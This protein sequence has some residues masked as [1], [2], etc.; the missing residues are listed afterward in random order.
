MR[1]VV[2]SALEIVAAVAGALAGWV[3]GGFIGR[4]HA[5]TPR[6]RPSA[7]RERRPHERLVA[8]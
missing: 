6:T 7:R 3:L 4:L 1:E 8:A 2:M 5:L